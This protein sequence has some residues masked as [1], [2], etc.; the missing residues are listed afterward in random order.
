MNNTITIDQLNE[1]T[2][3]YIEAALWSSNDESDPS[4]GEPIDK[5]YFIKDIE[6]E[7]LIKMAAE[8][9]S[10]QEE[11]STDLALAYER[12]ETGG[13]YGTAE[14]RA[15]H[16][17]WLTRCGHGEGFWS[18]SELKGDGLGRQLTEASNKVGERHLYISNGKVYQ[19][20][21]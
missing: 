18:R 12:Y 19:E 9:K 3:A 10:F 7:S 8:C 1:F 4:G 5:N 2:R 11:N 13:D 15:G 20:N 21:G 16:D 6:P 14:S 17:F